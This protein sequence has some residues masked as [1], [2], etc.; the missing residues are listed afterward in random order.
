M[1]RKRYFDAARSENANQVPIGGDESNSNSTH[2]KRKRHYQDYNSQLPPWK[3]GYDD[4]SNWNSTAAGYQSTNGDNDLQQ[5]NGDT[6]N[7]HVTK[8][9]SS[10]RGGEFVNELLPYLTS[11]SESIKNG[12]Y[13]SLTLF[14]SFYFT[15][16][17]LV[18]NLGE[19]DGSEMC[20][21]CI[22][23]CAG[24]E[25]DI[26]SSKEGALAIEAIFGHSPSYSCRYLQRLFSIK[27]TSIM[28]LL[29]YGWYH[30]L[31]FHM[32]FFN[33]FSVFSLNF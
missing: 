14:W 12:S 33:G 18:I 31:H 23:E 9:H 8:Q 5:L 16:C 2:S 7:Q 32:A 6:D 21:K 29:D 25:A 10:I 22:G 24:Y 4:S 17:S 27:Q 15:F 3:D 30:F 13:L 11:L 1:G 26:V 19:M 28:A 20:E